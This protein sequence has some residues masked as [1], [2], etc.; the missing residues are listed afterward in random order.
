MDSKNREVKTKPP[1]LMNASTENG[2]RLSMQIVTVPQAVKEG[3]APCQ[4]P[5]RNRP[6]G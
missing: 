3:T 5:D 2:A 6:H 1:A 4:A